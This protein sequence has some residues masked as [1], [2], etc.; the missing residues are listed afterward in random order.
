MHRPASRSWR[1]HRKKALMMPSHND[2]FSKPL[3]V[4]RWY[5]WYCYPLDLPPSCWQT[6]GNVDRLPLAFSPAPLVLL[7]ILLP[8]WALEGSAWQAARMCLESSTEGI[9]YRWSSWARGL[10][11]TLLRRQLIMQKQFPSAKL[12]NL[13][14]GRKRDIVTMGH[15]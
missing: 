7:P 11:W 12:M 1:R 3:N 6:P 4:G 5:R 9:E 15:G 10:L 14:N 13:R 8:V 2:F